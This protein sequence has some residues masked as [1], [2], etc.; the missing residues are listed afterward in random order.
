MSTRIKVLRGECISALEL[1]QKAEQTEVL[2][3]HVTVADELVDNLMGDVEQL[4]QM[5]LWIDML[6]IL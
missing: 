6:V 3:N 2:D 1:K 5:L 4:E